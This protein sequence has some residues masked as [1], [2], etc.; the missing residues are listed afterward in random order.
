MTYGWGFTLNLPG[1]LTS[2]PQKSNPPTADE[3]QEGE[4]P[5]KNNARRLDFKITESG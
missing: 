1:I 3:L 2:R 5:L 4:S